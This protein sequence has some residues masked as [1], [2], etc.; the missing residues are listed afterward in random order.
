VFNS[1][2]SYLACSF[3]NIS[4]KFRISIGFAYFD[5]VSSYYSP[6]ECLFISY[7]DE[8]KPEKYKLYNIQSCL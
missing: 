7:R 5:S 4:S 6:E 1:F 2:A 8:D 3:I